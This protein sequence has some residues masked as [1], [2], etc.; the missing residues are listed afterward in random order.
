MALD[1]LNQETKPTAIIAMNDLM[2]AG[3]IQA[4]KEMRLQV[5][6]DISVIGFDNRELSGY[7][8]PKLTTMSLPLEDMGKMAVNILHQ[9]K[10]NQKVVQKKYLLDCHLVKRESVYSLNK[11]A[12]STRV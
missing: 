4:I 5:P 6:D 11:I 10:L 12:P 2:A 3:A 1:L 7:H 8:S 9:I